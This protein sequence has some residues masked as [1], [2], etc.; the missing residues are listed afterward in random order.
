MPLS[1]DKLL[2]INGVKVKSIEDVSNF[3]NQLRVFEFEIADKNRTSVPSQR[4]P[5]LGMDSQKNGP[6]GSSLTPKRH[7]IQV[8]KVVPDRNNTKRNRTCGTKDSC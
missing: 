5:C 6:D 1:G 3:A 7:A 4:T 8:Y 2:S